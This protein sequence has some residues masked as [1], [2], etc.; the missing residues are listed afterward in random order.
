MA[1]LPA[2]STLD[3]LDDST[4]SIGQRSDP[5]RDEISNVEVVG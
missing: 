3:Y 5:F 2:C 4:V 1:Y